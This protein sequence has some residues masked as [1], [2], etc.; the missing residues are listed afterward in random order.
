[1]LPIAVGFSTA[2]T[3]SF[4]L[5]ILAGRLNGELKQNNEVSAQVA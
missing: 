1:V 5:L 2:G 3:V 4:S